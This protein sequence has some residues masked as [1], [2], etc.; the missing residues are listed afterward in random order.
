[1]SGIGPPVPEAQEIHQDPDVRDGRR[2]QPRDGEGLV[3][4]LG[5]LARAATPPP[6]H[7]PASS[8]GA[9]HTEGFARP[10]LDLDA[11]DD[12]QDRGARTA[13]HHACF[14][15]RLRADRAIPLRRTRDDGYLTP[16]HRRF[17]AGAGLDGGRAGMFTGDRGTS[18]AETAAIPVAH[19]AKHVLSRIA[20]TVISGSLS[21]T[22][23][24]S[25]PTRN[26]ARRHHMTVPRELLRIHR[27]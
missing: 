15:G 3:E 6:G 13:R 5:D 1:M 20:L 2:A 9:G 18:W 17:R 23:F 22:G 4:V 19:A 7:S 24:E 25:T 10:E 27:L 21:C 12:A 26:T 14:G 16:R 8:A 11:I